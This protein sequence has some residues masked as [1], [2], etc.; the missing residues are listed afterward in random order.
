[1]L[2]ELL[3]EGAT[4]VPDSGFAVAWSYCL[5]SVTGGLMLPLVGADAILPPL[6]AL[7][8]PPTLPAVDWPWAAVATSIT[9]AVRI[10]VLVMIDSSACKESTSGAGR[11]LP[12]RRAN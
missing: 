4:E 11:R 1:L 5:V 6:W 2:V 10:M 8:L 12:G 9:A 3:L 7:T